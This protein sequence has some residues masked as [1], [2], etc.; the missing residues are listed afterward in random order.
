MVIH[1]EEKC[2]FKSCCQFVPFVLGQQF[3]TRGDS[4]PRTHLAMS[5][6]ILSCHDWSGDA[7][8]MLLKSYNA[9]DNLPQKGIITFIISVVSS[10]RNADL[11][12]KAT[13]NFRKRVLWI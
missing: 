2:Y 1:T 4:A 12:V 7:T 10:L 6:D 9:Q 8:G 3:S 13:Y 5:G 11:E